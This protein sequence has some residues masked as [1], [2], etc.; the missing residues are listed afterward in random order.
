MRFTAVKEDNLVIIDGVGFSGI[1]MSS[2]PANF[3][4]V[5]WYGNAGE[6]ERIDPETKVKTNV[7]IHEL[8]PYQSLIDQWYVK[9]AE[10]EAPRPPPEPEIPYSIT[11]RQCALQLLSMGVITGPEAVAMAKDGTPPQFVQSYIKN[12]TESQSY[13]A[14]IDFASYTYLRNN[15][16]L[17]TLTAVNNM[18]SEQVDEF[19]VAA[20]KL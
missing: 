5:Q 11:R 12:L 20:D 2:M 15:P 14:E 19:F 13:I 18:T 8:S 17:A 7:P 4:A 1:D 3:W 9:K 16:L 10:S 6:E